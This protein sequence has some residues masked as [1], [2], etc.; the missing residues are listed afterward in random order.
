M[1]SGGRASV[2]VCKGSELLNRDVRG[3]SSKY[4]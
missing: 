4:G 3:S 1:W 2:R